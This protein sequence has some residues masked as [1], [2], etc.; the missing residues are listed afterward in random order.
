M[1]TPYDYP[2]SSRF[3]ENDA[4]II[5]DNAFH[6]WENVLVHRDLDMLMKFYP[7]SG[8]FNGFTFQACIRMGGKAGLF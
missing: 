8:F 7:Q 4:I 1:G 5:F 2:L 3:D 6:P